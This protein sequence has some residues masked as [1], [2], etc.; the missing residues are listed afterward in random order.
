M[1]AYSSDLEEFSIFLKS[2]YTTNNL[3][4]ATSSMIRS[5]LVALFEQQNTARSINRK[6]SSLKAFYRYNIKQGLLLSDPLIKVIAPRQSMSLPVFLSEKKMSEL[7]A[8]NLFSD[9]FEGYRDKLIITL[10]YATGI[11]RAELLNLDIPDID[12]YNNTIKVTGKRN[13]QRIIPIGFDLVK[14]V[15]DYI[16]IRNKLIIQK[17]AII[18][19]NHNRVFVTSSTKPMYER[20]LHNIV[21]KYLAYVSSQNKLSPHVLRHTFATQMLNNGADINAIKELLGH[22]S[23]AATQVYTHNTIEKLKKIH[24]Q[25]HPRA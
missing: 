20:L 15:E 1:K 18:Q 2:Q 6:L 17:S 22:S 9:D 13:K 4:E 14:Q 21:H 19:N 24:K 7:L 11:R 23:L 16:I 10:L 5:W 12:L 25:A 3:L 8:S